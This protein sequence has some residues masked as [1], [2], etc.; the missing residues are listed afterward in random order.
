MTEQRP[1]VHARLLGI[2]ERLHAPAIRARQHA[3]VGEEP[4]AGVD[5][6]QGRAR[7]AGPGLPGQHHRLALA[8]D[9]GCVEEHVA[10][11]EHGLG[12]RSRRRHVRAMLA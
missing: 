9:A 12:A 11:M 1:R 2:A 4:E 6:M 10:A 8:R 5:Q 3:V 7:F